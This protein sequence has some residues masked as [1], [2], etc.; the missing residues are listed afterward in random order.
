[1]AASE[2]DQVASHPG[3]TG[4]AVAGG[5]GVHA[6]GLGWCLGTAA[7]PRSGARPAARHGV[8]GPH[9]RAGASKSGLCRAQGE[10]KPSECLAIRVGRKLKATDV[11]DVLSDLFIWRDVPGHVHS[12]N[13][14]KFVARAVCEWITTLGARTAFI[15]PGSPWENRYCESFNSK[16]RDEL[17]NGEIF[18][19][20]R[21]AEIVIEGWRQHYNTKRPHSALSSRPPAPT[22]VPWPKAPP[23]PASP[24]TST[25][26]AKPTM[27]WI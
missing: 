17:L 8:S 5:A 14:T 27:H 23:Q 6:L 7:Q 9:Q 12:D 10:L 2:W 3:R 15:E 1:M 20:L 24:T 26:A 4:T 19:S 25:V 11:I 16:L 22:A 18:Y 21:E 13:G